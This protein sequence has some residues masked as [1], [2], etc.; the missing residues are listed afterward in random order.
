M[1]EKQSLNNK[2]KKITNLSC[3]NRLMVE[4]WQKVVGNENGEIN[5]GDKNGKRKCQELN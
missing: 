4:D 5:V 2:R 1:K 3:Q